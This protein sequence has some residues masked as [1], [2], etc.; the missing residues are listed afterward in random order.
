MNARLA[1]DIYFC[2]LPVFVGISAGIG[3]YIGLYLTV[4]RDYNMKYAPLLFLGG[5][6]SGA[7]VGV[8]YPIFIPWGM[9]K[10]TY[11]LIK[12]VN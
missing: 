6:T 10:F 3:G 12:D 9:Y 2:T 11:E 1:R 8:A 7:I 5:I 4:K